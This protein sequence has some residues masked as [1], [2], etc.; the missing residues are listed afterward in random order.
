MNILDIITTVQHLIQTR[1]DFRRNS[2]G[3][4]LV[5]D[6]LTALAVGLVNSEQIGAVTDT[7]S[8]TVNKYRLRNGLMEAW[9]VQTAQ[10]AKACADWLLNE[11]H[12]H[13]YDQLLEACF[14]P[15]IPPSTDAVDK[16][17]LE[18]VENLKEAL[19]TLQESGIVRDLSELKTGCVGW[20]MARLV[21]IARMCY[22]CGYLSESEAWSY[23]REARETVASEL[24][25]WQELARSYIIGRA[26]WA[27]NDM[28]LDGLV[29][30]ATKGQAAPE[31]PWKKLPWP[32]P[33]NQAD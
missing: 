25:S 22:D 19:E 13:L 11:G 28:M 14:T 6:D 1:G 26:M 24:N 17:S 3:S 10:E 32:T 31:S 33:E 27:G 16:E 21:C 12:R 23:I 8:T 15:G 18:Y 7:L 4:D 20:D 29:E 2:A 30:I 5:H 9:D